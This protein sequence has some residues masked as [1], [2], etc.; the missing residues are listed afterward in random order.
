ML[1]SP[2]LAD[3]L[4]FW[5]HASSIMKIVESDDQPTDV[6]K[7]AKCIRKEISNLVLN[8]DEYEQRIDKVKDKK[9]VS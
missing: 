8:K 9:C 1:S 4:V 2:G 3:V 5:K 6:S 7:A